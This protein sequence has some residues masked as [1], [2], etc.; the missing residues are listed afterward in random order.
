MQMVMQAQEGKRIQSDFDDI[1]PAATAPARSSS[2]SNSSVR[3]EDRR[4]EA[5]GSNNID[6]GKSEQLRSFVSEKKGKKIQ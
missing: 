1:S 5:R 3:V 6:N 4:G 2:S